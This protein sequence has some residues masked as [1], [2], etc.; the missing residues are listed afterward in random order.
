[1]KYGFVS[2]YSVAFFDVIWRKRNNTMSTVQPRKSKLGN[3][4]RVEFMRKASRVSK[5][6]K[7]KNKLKYSLH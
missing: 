7:L 1:M 3:T 2:S 4:Y 5:S 6:F